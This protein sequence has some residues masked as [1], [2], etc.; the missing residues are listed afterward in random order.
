LE[1][2]TGELVARPNAVIGSHQHNATGCLPRGA[3]QCVA[4]I[5][6]GMGIE[7]P[8]STPEQLE[9]YLQAEIPKRAR[10]VKRGGLQPQ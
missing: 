4:R 2:A 8:G 7:P 1:G 3:R 10:A 6:A 9:A 5:Y